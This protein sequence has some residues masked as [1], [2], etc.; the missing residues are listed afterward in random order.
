M[1]QLKKNLIKLT[2]VWKSQRTSDGD[3]VLLNR[4]IGTQAMPRLDPFLMLDYIESA[5]LPA[6]FPDHMHRGFE[7]VTYLIKGKFF[8]EDFKGNKGELNAGDVQWMTAGKGIVHA[9]MPASTEPSAGFQ[10]WIDLERAN[11]MCE[12]NYQEIKKS[13]IPEIQNESFFMRIIS[14]D[15]FGNKGACFSKNPVSYFDVQVNKDKEF[16]V[17]LGPGVN[18]FLFLFEGSE[19]NVQGTKVSR[20]FAASF[21]TD[22]DSTQLL[23]EAGNDADCRFLLVFGKPLNQPVFQRG[24]VVM[25]SEED[26][27]KAFSDYKLGINGFENARK[28]ESQIQY[29]NQKY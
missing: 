23:V 9:E 15:Y 21:S 12:P 28:W 5:A 1:E 25:C 14:G 20:M 7:T 22:K 3:G 24:P 18:G 2:K 19:V 11:K 10:L 27:Y 13:E 16:T 4:V 26:V 6:G 17:D 29:L 8:H